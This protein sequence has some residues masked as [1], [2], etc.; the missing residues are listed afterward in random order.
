[1]EDGVRFVTRVLEC[2]EFMDPAAIL[3]ATTDEAITTRELFSEATML[4]NGEPANPVLLPKTF[5]A[6]GIF[7]RDAMGQLLGRRPFERPWMAHYI[8]RRLAV[9]SALT[10]ARLDWKPR[11]RLKLLRRLPFLI[12]NLKTNPVEW[13][14]RNHAAMRKVE[15][16]VNLQIVRLLEKH[17][18]AIRRET[19][20]RIRQQIR[21]RRF[22]GHRQL[23]A[24]RLN[25]LVQVDLRHL[26]N[27]VRTREKTV[28]TSYC[29]D[30]A[31]RSHDLGFAAKEVC[32]SQRLLRGI[33]L[34]ALLS[35]PEAGGLEADIRRQ[36]SMTILFGCDQVLEV[37]ERLGD[38]P[39]SHAEAS[40]RDTT[41]TE[42]S[43]KGDHPER[44]KVSQ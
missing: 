42:L 26:I 41:G 19:A 34:R 9:D 7:A 12:E 29:R 3:L 39:P 36:V 31:K 23:S 4:C 38:S 18:A 11:E 43:V 6:A 30:L 33:C 25:W 20:E 35:D 5:C 16:D 40:Q 13:Y 10:R 37:Y 27:S 14:R 1:V 8:D 21:V 15:L 17:S 24:E 28:Y 32:A 2:H 44:L 22:P